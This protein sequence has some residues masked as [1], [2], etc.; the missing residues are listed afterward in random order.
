MNTLTDARLAVIANNLKWHTSEDIPSVSESSSMAAEL[1]KHRAAR[2][3][4]TW[5]MCDADVDRMERAAESIER[6]TA[7][8]NE[9]GEIVQ[10]WLAYCDHAGI[11]EDAERHPD[12]PELNPVKALCTRSRAALARQS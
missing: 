7:H 11:D 12:N 2:N 5:P 10:T 4:D 1:I 6:L 3:A 8:R 9:L